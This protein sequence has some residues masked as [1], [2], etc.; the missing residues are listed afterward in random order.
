M[1]TTVIGKWG[2]ASALRIP[3]PFCELLGINIGDEVHVSV[4]DARRIVIE[5]VKDEYSLKA[6]MKNWD[7]ERYQCIEENWGNP[8][9]KEIW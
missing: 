6:R 8:V 5:S 9:G 4:E 3:K 2:N 1:T 7:G